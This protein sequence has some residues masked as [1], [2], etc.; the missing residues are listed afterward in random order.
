[1]LIIFDGDAPPTK[2]RMNHKLSNNL[3][4]KYQILR[5]L[6]SGNSGDVF[7]ARHQ[8]LESDRAI[9]II[10]KSIGDRLTIL[11]EA[12]VLKELDHPGIPTVY[13]VEEDADYYY[14]IEEYVDGPSLAEY[15]LQKKHISLSE[16]IQIVCQLCDIYSYLHAHKLIYQDIKP[17]HILLSNQQIKVIDFGA[18]YHMSETK[19]SQKFFGNNA[20][21]APE[22][23]K[24]HLPTVSSDV[25]SI[26][27]IMEYLIPFLDTSVPKAIQHI[28]PKATESAPALRFETVAKLKEMICKEL[29]QTVAH[30][31]KTIVI[32]G[33]FSGCGS[34]H[35]SIALTSVLNYY[36]N[37]CYFVESNNSKA[38]I[39]MRQVAPSLSEKNGILSYKW[40]RGLPQYG[41]GI[42]TSI[43]EHEIVI[44]DAGTNYDPTLLEDADICLLICGSSP[45][46]VM[47][48]M[49]TTEALGLHAGAFPR[50]DLHFVI[51]PGNSYI[52]NFLE[53]QYPWMVHSYVYDP[54]PFRVSSAKQTFCQEILEPKGRDVSFS[55]LRKIM[56]HIPKP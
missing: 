24:G 25:Y 8:S 44:K 29:S 19:K 54:D 1:M 50:L 31:P 21:S 27:R 12:R 33:T 3:S 35:I 43:P 6:G 34:T 53:L 55:R 51:N 56:H 20:F 7:L 2:E 28:I 23:L 46:H 30:S 5:P 47:D 42:Q 39:H 10:P 18:L 40:F 38:L 16:Y 45:W 41:P 37:P 11:Q 22:V 13:D 14:F 36:M 4:G 32:F 26:G 9:K 15:V 17:A 52:K 49:E 48:I